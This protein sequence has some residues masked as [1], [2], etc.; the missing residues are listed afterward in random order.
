MTG[1]MED[2]PSLSD[3]Q[4]DLLTK[5][6]ARVL[7]ETEGFRM[8]VRNSLT[9]ESVKAFFDKERMCALGVAGGAIAGSLL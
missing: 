3:E 9:Q 4:S 8:Q 2:I 6:K 5:V 1:M 7:R